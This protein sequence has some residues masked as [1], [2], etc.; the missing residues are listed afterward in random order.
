MTDKLKREVELFGQNFENADVEE[1][2]ALRPAPAAAA[3]AAKT[4]LGKFGSSK[5]KATA[6][7]GKAKYQFQVRS[8]A[9][10]V[11][12]LFREN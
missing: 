12:S 7:A 2:L 3:V 10:K 8:S 6:K 4:D 1:V 5:S 11:V 9:S